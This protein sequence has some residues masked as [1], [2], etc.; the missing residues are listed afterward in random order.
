MRGSTR[1]KKRQRRRV[2]IGV[3]VTCGCGSKKLCNKPKVYYKKEE[4]ESRYRKIFS[5][6]T[7]FSAEFQ[8]GLAD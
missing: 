1:N 3:E 6:T 5:Q 4:A 2:K 7:Q 8:C